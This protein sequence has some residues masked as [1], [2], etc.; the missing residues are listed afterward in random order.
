MSDLRVNAKA[1]ARRLRRHWIFG[2]AALFG[3]ALLVSTPAWAAPVPRP[4]NQTVPRPTPTS[5]SDPIPTATPSPNDDDGGDSGGDTGGDSGGQPGAPAGDGDTFSQPATGSESAPALTYTAVVD[6]ASLNVRQGPGTSFAIVGALSAGDTVTVTARNEDA[7][8][9]FICCA[10]NTGAQGWSSA[11]LLTPSFDR[12][13]AAALL[14][15]FGSTATPAPAASTAAASS[16]PLAAPLVVETELDP[17]FVWQGITGTLTIQ[18][19]NPNTETVLQARLSDELPAELTLLGATADSD[20]EV[21]SDNTLAGRP[22]IIATWPSIAGGTSVNVTI[23]F[24][25]DSDLDAGDV[26]DNLFALRGANVAYQ[27][28]VVTIGMPPMEPPRFD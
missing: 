25:V 24:Q 2:V 21:R 14:P 1:I 16:A 6:V 12:A 19:T 11:Q 8:W 5:P 23:T 26:V 15:L 7:S 4:A 22:L 27:T 3:V 18:I 17:P 10:T 9:W 13:Q 28:G 20:G